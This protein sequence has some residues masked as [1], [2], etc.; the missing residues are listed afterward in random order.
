M[1]LTHHFPLFY[2]DTEVWIGLVKS[3]P[4]LMCKDADCSGLM[5]WDS[6]ATLQY[7]D[8]GNDGYKVGGVYL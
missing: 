1:S 3:D 2:L 4:N 8:L 5:S 6:G 7:V